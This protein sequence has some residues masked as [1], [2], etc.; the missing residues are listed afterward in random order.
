MN[1]APFFSH[2][3]RWAREVLQDLYRPEQTNY[4]ALGPVINSWEG[5]IDDGRY[6]RHLHTA[7][8]ETAVDREVYVLETDG[9]IKPDESVSDFIQR[10]DILSCAKDDDSEN[11][12]DVFV[13]LCDAYHNIPNR[14]RR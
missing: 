8:I 9:T 3:A 7:V 14:E 11:M 5:S 12:I 6:L 10:S 2:E 1:E 4:I 13:S